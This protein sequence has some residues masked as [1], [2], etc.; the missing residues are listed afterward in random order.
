M[1]K[2]RKE[3]NIWKRQGTRDKEQE[4]RN[5]RQGTRDKEQETLLF[6]L[7]NCTISHKIITFAL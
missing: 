4:T 3:L 2:V 1:A 6:Y 5:K 7:I